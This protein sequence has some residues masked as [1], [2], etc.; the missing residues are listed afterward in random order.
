MPE[1][2]FQ[3]R[4]V[5]T[6]ADLEATAQLFDAYASSLG[7]DLSFQD[8]TAEQ[9]TLPGKYAPPA[10]ELLLARLPGSAVG[11]RRAQT[12]ATRRLLRDEAAL[13]RASRTRAWPR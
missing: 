5:R 11:M 13:R 3:I 8:F 10:G 1:I 12:D 7:V 2:L 4:P 6:A 9:A